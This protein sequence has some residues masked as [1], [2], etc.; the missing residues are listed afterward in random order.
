LGAERDGAGEG[1]DSEKAHGLGL[2]LVAGLDELFF[3]AASVLIWIEADE[4]G[5]G[6]GFIGKVRN[7]LLLVQKAVGILAP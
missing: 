4:A 1:E 7:A 3:R 6:I 2:V 5:R